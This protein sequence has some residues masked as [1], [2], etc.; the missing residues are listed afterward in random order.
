MRPRASPPGLRTLRLIVVHVLRFNLLPAGGGPV[1]GARA[2]WVAPNK[3]EPSVDMIMEDEVFTA[4]AHL[5]VQQQIERR[6]HDLWCGGEYRPGTAL[7]DW[8][9][10]ER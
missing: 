1:F 3:G 7:N 4:E 10:A 9:Q 6:A 5:G 2:G 8:L